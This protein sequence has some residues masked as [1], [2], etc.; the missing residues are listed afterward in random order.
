[1]TITFISDTAYHPLPEETRPQ[2][3]GNVMQWIEIKDIE[4]RLAELSDELEEDYR[5]LI[6]ALKQEL[7]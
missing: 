5:D 3:V 4:L 2:A 6:T 7:S 1:M